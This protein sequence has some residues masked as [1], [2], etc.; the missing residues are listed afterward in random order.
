MKKFAKLLALVLI[1]VVMTAALAGC[2]VA[3]KLNGKWE[4]KLEES[5]L[6]AEITMEFDKKAGEVE[7]TV[8]ALGFEESDTADF[9]VKGKKLIIDD[10]EVEYKIKGKTLTIEFDGEELELE[11]VKK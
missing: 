1:V 2:G 7:V 3:S 10:E 8:A 11:K 9:E 5:G 4:G 6:T